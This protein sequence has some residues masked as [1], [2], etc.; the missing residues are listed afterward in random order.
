M[1]G[2]RVILA[3]GFLIL[4]DRTDFVMLTDE[5]IFTLYLLPVSCGQESIHTRWELTSLD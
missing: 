5:L 4:R 3:P 1:V 2:R